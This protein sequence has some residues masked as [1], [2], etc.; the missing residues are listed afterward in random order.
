[1]L[2]WF[3]VTAWGSGYLATKAGLQYAPPFTFL[4]LRF[5][6]GVLLLVPLAVWWHRREPP[7]LGEKHAD[8][9]VH[10]PF[11][12]STQGGNECLC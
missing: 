1:M 7:V 3:F 12:P 9:L 6:T 10:K 5:A 2:A 8:E 11:I 4:V